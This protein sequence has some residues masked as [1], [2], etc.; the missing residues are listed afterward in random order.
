MSERGVSYVSASELAALIGSGS[1]LVV[2]ARDSDYGEGGIISGAQHTAY[3]GITAA[4][5]QALLDAAAQRGAAR[6]VTYCAYGQVR[7]VKLARVLTSY[8]ESTG[9][10]SRVA[11]SVLAR[12]FDGFRAAYGGTALVTRV[13]PRG[14]DAK[15]GDDHLLPNFQK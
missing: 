10:L 7:S 6:I 15:F 3:Y 11:I 2:D 12:G 13:P 5:C 4:A 1:V 14:A 8:A 9:Q